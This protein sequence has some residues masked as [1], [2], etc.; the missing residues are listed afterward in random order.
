MLQQVL[1][2][3][4]L[5]WLLLPELSDTEANSLSQ[6]SGK[7]LW[8]NTETEEKLNRKRGKHYPAFAEVIGEMEG[9]VTKL[10]GK[11]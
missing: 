9:L 4:T 2:E 5:Q 7:E 8:R 3:R 10:M 6:T 11:H 1:F